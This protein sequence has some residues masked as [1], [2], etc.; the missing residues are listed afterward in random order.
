MTVFKYMQVRIV[1]S[2]VMPQKYYGRVG[3]PARNPQ[4]DQPKL[5]SRD[6]PCRPGKRH[7]LQADLTKLELNAGQGLSQSWNYLKIVCFVP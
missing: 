1:F 6:P 7:V 4:G 5:F 3:G 2:D